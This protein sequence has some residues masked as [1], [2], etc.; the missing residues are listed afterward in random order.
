[1]SDLVSYTAVGATDLRY[2][3]EPVG[4]YGSMGHR[5]RRVR[6]TPEMCTALD[7]ALTA[8]GE[9]CPAGRPTH[10]VTAG[11]QADRRPDG[12]PR[13]PDDRHRQGVAVDIDSLWWDR[14]AIPAVVT[15][16]SRGDMRRYLGV[17]ACLRMEFGTVLGWEYNRA[18]RDHWH[19]DLGSDVGFDVRSRSRVLFVQAALVELWGERL[20]LDGVFGPLTAAAATHILE[21]VDDSGLGLA[22]LPAWRRFLWAAAGAGWGVC[23][24]G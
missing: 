1:M 24:A 17:E 16:H 8:I 10:L 18:H 5:S 13:A 14:S 21:Q 7:R 2:A 22:H 9:V 3:R 19:C 6:S 4:V 23:E 11:C 20:V 15:L 12:S